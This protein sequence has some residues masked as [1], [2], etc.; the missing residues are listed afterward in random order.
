[1]KNS[2]K[3]APL[4]SN[5]YAFGNDELSKLLREVADAVDKLEGDY[6]IWGLYVEHGD[7]ERGFNWYAHIYLNADIT[8][9]D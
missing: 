3:G 7:G 6:M 5:H 9:N 4:K 1:M 2:I 8:P